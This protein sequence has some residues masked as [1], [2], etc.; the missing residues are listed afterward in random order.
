MVAT[1]GDPHA[2]SEALVTVREAAPL[3]GVTPD[4]MWRWLQRGLLPAQTSDMA[5]PISGGG[6][7]VPCSTL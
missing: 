7:A 4:T 3:V 1:D 5:M 2:E 6:L